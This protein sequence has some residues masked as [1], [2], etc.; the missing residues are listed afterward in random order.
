MDWSNRFNFGGFFVNYWTFQIPWEVIE[1][2][3]WTQSCELYKFAQIYMIQKLCR[4]GKSWKPL[5]KRE[6]V[7]A[8]TFAPQRIRIQQRLRLR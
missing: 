6:A 5:R 8:A 7:E 1:K 4:I 3:V 2:K